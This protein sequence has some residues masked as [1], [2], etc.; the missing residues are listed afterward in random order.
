MQRRGTPF[1]ITTTYRRI[2][3]LDL[4]VARTVEG[5]IPT[6][7]RMRTFTLLFRLE[8]TYSDYRLAR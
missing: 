2:D 6:R 4:P 7:R 3:G 8:A 1:T 5:T